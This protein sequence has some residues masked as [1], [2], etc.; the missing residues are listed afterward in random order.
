MQ[1]KRIAE[2]ADNLNF[3]SEEIDEIAAEKPLS[4]P[5]RAGGKTRIIYLEPE[6]LVEY[7]DEDFERATGRQQPFHEYS[8]EEFD[9]LVE[10]IRENGIMQP[11]VVRPYCS[12]YQILA[13]RHRSRAAKLLGIKVP[14]VVR[15]D[16][17]DTSAARI[18]LDTNLEQ[19]PQPKYSELAYAY[20][21]Q[22]ELS[23]KQ[24]HR[25]DLDTSSNG[26][27]KLDTAGSI[28]KK[29]GKSRSTVHNYIRLSYLI[30]GMLDA[31]DNKV[32]EMMAGV[33]LSYITEEYQKQ[34]LAILPEYGK[35]KK[36]TANDLRKAFEANKLTEAGIRECLTPKPKEKKPTQFTV[37]MKRLAPYRD[38]LPNQET[39]ESLF[40]EF[41]DQLKSSMQQ[42][43]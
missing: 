20:R 9:S 19:R 32:I 10:S 43:P 35:M 30:P 36:K 26:W 28:G 4:R 18:M 24:G 3:V 5:I 31:V 33:E 27:T 34:I 39:L 13:G 16:V 41:L 23:K 1:V 11:A 42:A 38:I 25:S 2:L 15:D 8:G 14:C 40:L 37:S 29:D 21:M 7:T 17:D 12:K 22:T 6:E